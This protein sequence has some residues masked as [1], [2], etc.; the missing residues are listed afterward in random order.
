MKKFL[1]CFAVLSAMVFMIGCGKALDQAKALREPQ[2]SSRSS[3]EMSWNDAKAY[4]SNLNEGGH[5]DWRLP[6]IDEVKSL[7]RNCPNTQLLCKVSEKNDCL[8]K[9]CNENCSCGFKSRN[10]GYYST[11]KDDD[12]V[13]LWSSS[14]TSVE[15]ASDP[16]LVLKKF[17]GEID[18]LPEITCALIVDF[19]S[20]GINC[21]KMSS[22]QSVRCIR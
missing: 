4:C 3:K 12:K 22:H 18:K 21:Y 13:V 15:D 9:Y 11:L 17:N 1:V 14:T 2:W 19:S 16:K 5:K 6:N 10:A 8:S 7:V 20:A